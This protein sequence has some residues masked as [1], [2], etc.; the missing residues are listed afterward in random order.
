MHLSL[1]TQLTAQLQ[2]KSHSQLHC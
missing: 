1:T 2:T